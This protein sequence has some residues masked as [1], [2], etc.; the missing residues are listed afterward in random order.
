MAAAQPFKV[1]YASQVK[2]HLKAI[3]QKYHPLIRNT[4]K[5]QLQWEP[6]I[7]TR[8][9]KPLSRPIEFGADWEIRFGP[10]NSSR[11][12]SSPLWSVS[13]AVLPRWSA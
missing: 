4:I 9:K 7:E 5:D 6:A 10:D 3:A 11:P 12:I 1:I 8:N 13:R 2:A